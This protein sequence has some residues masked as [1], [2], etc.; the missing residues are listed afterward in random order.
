MQLLTVPD[1]AAKYNTSIRA[2]QA[3]I[4]DG[5]LPAILVGKQYRIDPENMG[6]FVRKVVPTI[7]PEGGAS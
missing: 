4:K 5:R 3:A 1:V 6:T 2:V 7:N